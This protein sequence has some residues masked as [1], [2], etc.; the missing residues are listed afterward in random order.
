MC[1]ISGVYN[2]SSEALLPRAQM[3]NALTRMN[4]AQAHRGPDDEGLW[5]SENSQVGFGHRRLAIID[6]SPAGHQP[7]TNEDGSI[8]LTYNGEIYNFMALKKELQV[9]GHNFHSHT[10]TEVVIHAYEEWGTDSFLRFRG[11]FAFALWDERQR[12]L[13]LVKD[14]FGIKPLYYYQDADRLAFASEVRDLAG[15]GLFSPQKNPDALTAFLLLGSV[16]MPLTTF[17]QVHGLPGGHYLVAENGRARLVR[18]YDLWADTA[19]DDRAQDPEALRA[20]LSET[21]DLHLISDAPIGVFLSGG[22]DSSALVALA[23]LAHRSQITTL[24]INFEE[25]Q[26]SEER[27]Q[28]LVSRKYLTDHHSLVLTR[29]R[30]L[31]D[32][33]QSLVALDQP[34]IDGLNTWFVSL[35]AK[36]AG[37][38][39]VLAGTGGDEVFCGYPHFHQAGLLTRLAALGPLFRSMGGSLE[40]LPG[41]WRKLAFLGLHRNLGWYEAIRGLFTPPEV[42]RLTG[43]TLAHVRDVANA[44]APAAPPWPPVDRLSRYEIHFYLQN[45]LLKDTDCM[46][47]AHGVETRVPFLDPVL[48]QTV[49]ASP[50]A[51]RMNGHVP[52]V[53]L[54][55]ALGD[56]LPP[57]VVYRPKMTFTFPFETWLRDWP[58]WDAVNQG[59]L[60]RTTAAAIL[61]DY[62]AGRRNWTRPWALIIADRMFP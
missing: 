36:K 1:G 52:K 8:W 62:H 14:R 31:K 51:S 12:R 16:P 38:K 7:M 25:A 41:P 53:L 11:M 19:P 40:Y 39:A 23:A 20:I 61:A 5:F 45:Q 55:Q 3:L 56:L 47:M 34:S 10:D 33:P 30:F 26:F 13:Y 46:S 4:Q 22:I 35:M 27:Y 50:P 21:V 43:D 9:L 6:L 37:L 28:R 57:E 44:L 58:G 29:Q 54:T 48:V 2:F 42:A 60:D 59:P 17:K 18:Y 24:S 32:L 49:L 15:S